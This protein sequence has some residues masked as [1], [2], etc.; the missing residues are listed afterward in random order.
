MCWGASPAAR[1]EGDSPKLH[2]AAGSRRSGAV[3]A[4]YQVLVKGVPPAEAYLEL[5]RYGS[6]PVAES[7]LLAF[8]NSHMEELAALLVERKVI[9]EMPDPLPLF[10]PPA[11]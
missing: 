1:S 9:D 2:C 3:V 10:E 4:T 7:P 5:D 11:S 6:R 8:L